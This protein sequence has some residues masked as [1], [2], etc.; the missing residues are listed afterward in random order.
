MK[1]LSACFERNR[2]QPRPHPSFEVVEQ[3]PEQ[4]LSQREMRQRMSQQNQP[5]NLMSMSI[6]EDSVL[7]NGDVDLFELVL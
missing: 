6:Q 1:V 5:R 4:R 7:G 2:R 3:Q